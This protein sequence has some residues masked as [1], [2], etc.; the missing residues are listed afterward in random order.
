[1]MI[2][3]LNDGETWSGIDGCTIRFVPDNYDESDYVPPKIIQILSE[4]RILQMHSALMMMIEAFESE[5]GQSSEV[6]NATCDLI[7]SI[8][9]PE[10]KDDFAN[11]INATDG[12][13]YFR[14]VQCAED[15]MAKW[16]PEA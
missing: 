16:Y 11:K 8:R 2:G 1:M 15:F 3:M 7:E 4:S 12:S 6:Y 10:M 5:M 14:N 9:G 13:F